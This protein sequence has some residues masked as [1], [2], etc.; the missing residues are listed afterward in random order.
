MSDDKHKTTT[1]ATELATAAP[2]PVQR[3]F[4]ASTD[5]PYAGTTKAK[6]PKQRAAALRREGD[7]KATKGK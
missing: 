1:A 3:R 7:A 4:G 5:D 6:C 2:Q